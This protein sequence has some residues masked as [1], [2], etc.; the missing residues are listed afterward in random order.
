M[1]INRDV[2]AIVLLAVNLKPGRDDGIKIGNRP[3]HFIMKIPS[4]IFHPFLLQIPG[5]NGNLVWRS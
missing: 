4:S 1:V 2:D 3:I 5:R